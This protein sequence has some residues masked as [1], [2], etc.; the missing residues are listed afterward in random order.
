MQRVR[1]GPK[2]VFFCPKWLWPAKSIP[3]FKRC[4]RYT[5][6]Q[7]APRSA[8]SFRLAPSNSA[9]PPGVGAP[10]EPRQSRLNGKSGPKINSANNPQ[11]S[12]SQTLADLFIKKGVVLLS[13]LVR[14]LVRIPD[15]F[16]PISQFPT[17]PMG[18]G[19]SVVEKS[20]RRPA[21]SFH[22]RSASTWNTALNLE[23]ARA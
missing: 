14:G 1:G 20:I 12:E 15:R 18:L 21:P 23:P 22:P 17:H 11:S 5:F 6:R 8:V 7:G 9:T 2:F 10:L 3:N 19:S 16:D 13:D 4:L